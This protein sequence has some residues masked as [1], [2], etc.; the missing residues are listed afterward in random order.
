MSPPD[1]AQA[2]AQAYAPSI[3]TGSAPSNPPGI[4]LSSAPSN[5]RTYVLT[6]KLLK[7]DSYLSLGDARVRVHQNPPV[8]G[9]ITVRAAASRG[10]TVAVIR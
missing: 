2:Y 6:D 3:Q 5:A 9:Q 4:A 8:R 10:L 7:L 1:D